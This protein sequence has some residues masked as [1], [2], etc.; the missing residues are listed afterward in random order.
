MCRWVPG[1]PR[2]APGTGAS[3]K[4][5]LNVYSHFAFNYFSGNTDNLLVGWRFGA[6]GLGFYKKAFDLFCLPACQLLSP[7]GAVVVATL[8]RFNRNRADY[9]RYF[10]SGF[11][12][13]ALI[14]MGIGADLTL[15]GK[16]LIRLLMGPR[17]GETG[18]IFSFFG[19]GIGIMLLYGTHGWIHLS[20]GRPDRWFRWAVGEFLWTVCL[21]VVGLHWGPAGIAAAWT[22]SYFTLLLPAF[23]YAGK[24]IGFKVN[25]ILGIIWKFLAASI[26]AGGGTAGLFHVVPLFAATAGVAGALGRLASIS[27]VFCLLYLGLVTAFHSGPAPLRQAAGVL[28]DLLPRR[29]EEASLAYSKPGRTEGSTAL[30]QTS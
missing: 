11:S 14:G 12:V 30:A 24:P 8:S 9:Q 3:V 28:K 17:W 16:D 19:P 15:V 13:L 4:F 10:L 25:S 23:W 29:P 1:I 20:I 26:A 27:T 7:M 22:T 18:R 6:A 5:A 2:R 21:F